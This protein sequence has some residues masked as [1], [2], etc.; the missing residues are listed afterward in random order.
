MGESIRTNCV[1]FRVLHMCAKF[2]QPR[3]SNKKEKV[4]GP[5]EVEIHNNI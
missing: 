2:Q 1:Y 3:G 4:D 5:F